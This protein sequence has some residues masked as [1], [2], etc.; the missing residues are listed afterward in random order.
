MRKTAAKLSRLLKPALLRIGGD[1]V[2][3]RVKL[4]PRARRLIVKVHPVTGEVS[5]VAPSRAGLATVLDFAARQA[6]W[7]GAQRAHAPRRVLLG[8][9]AT[10]PFRG[11]D[12]PVRTGEKT[13]RPVRIE[14]GVLLISGRPEHA[15]RR[16]LDF[17]KREARKALENRIAEFAPRLDVRPSRL[18]IRDTASRWGSCSA[19]RALSFSWRLILA[20]DFVLDYVAAHEI[21]HLREMNHGPRFWSHVEKL[22]GDPKRAR[23]WLRE[24]GPALQRFSAKI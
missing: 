15:P 24:H 1:A 7:I 14:N 12:H 17:L 21:A 23:K 8:P 5:V 4:N 18:T 19:G 2:E 20:P 13:T 22:V 16:L 6:P 11:E 10:I 3:V 9:G